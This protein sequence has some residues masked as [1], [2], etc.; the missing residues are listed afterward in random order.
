MPMWAARFLFALA[1]GFLPRREDQDRGPWAFLGLVLA[2]FF[3]PVLVLM[4]FPLLLSF[5]P[6]VPDDRLEV[7]GQAAQEVRA[8]TGVDVPWEEVVAAWAA[9]HDQDFSTADLAS[10][11]QFAQNWVEERRTKRPDGSEEVSYSRRSF[12]E[13]LDLLGLNTGRKEAARR[14]L[15]TLRD[16]LQ[17]GTAVSGTEVAP[18]G[19]LTWPVPGY[20][21]ISSGYGLRI[22]PVTLLPNFHRAIDIPAPQGTPV[23]AAHAGVV[24]ETGRSFGL[25]NYVIVEGGGYWTQYGHLSAILVSPGQQVQA[26]QVIGLVGSTGLSTGPHLDFRVKHLGQW[27]NPLTFFGR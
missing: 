9:V 11:R 2:V 18:G 27:Q 8:A 21:R 10:V 14:Y 23:V 13:V 17:A 25:G 16:L 22:H 26:G 3:G 20:T 7:F 5:A 19:P 6:A 4:A 12:D 15:A 24:A 1:R